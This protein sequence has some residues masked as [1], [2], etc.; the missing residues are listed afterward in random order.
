MLDSLW[1]FGYAFMAFCALMVI[2]PYLRGRC[3]LITTWNLFWIGSLMFMGN[4]ALQAEIAI[5]N[6]PLRQWRALETADYLWFYVGVVTFYGTI[7]LVYFRFRGPTKLAGRL[8][9]KWPPMTV[10]SLVVLLVICFLVSL[11]RLVPVP[12]PFI[13][14]LGVQFGATAPIYAAV[15]ALVAWWR[16]RI[17]PVLLWLLIAAGAY[18]LLFSV[19]GGATGRRQLLG[20]LAIMPIC[21]YWLHW[22]YGSRKKT[23]AILTSAGVLGI[24]LLGSYSTFRHNREGMD[25]SLSKGLE[26]VMRL[27]TEMFSFESMNVTGQ[28]AVEVSLTAINVYRHELPAE[29]L[30]SLIFIA[31]NPVPR[32]FWEDKPVGLGLTFPQYVGAWRFGR[33]TWGPGI[34][35]HGFHEGGLHMLVVYGFLMGCFLRFFDSLLVEQ[36]WNPFLLAALCGSSGHILGWVRG[37]IGVFSIQIVNACVF[38]LVLSVIGRLIIGTGIVL[39]RTAGCEPALGLQQLQPRSP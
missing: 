31:V 32:Y 26:R 35:G 25:K 4:S 34:V 29:P 28:N 18:A 33:M 23:L 14:Q 9:R 12:I 36:P 27:P 2:V 3:D 22:R 21:L 8:L 20:T 30:H 6:P 16:D 11:L 37:D 5:R 17:N 13:G 10:Q 38:A 24:M 7:M 19:I 39:P 1:Y 15:F